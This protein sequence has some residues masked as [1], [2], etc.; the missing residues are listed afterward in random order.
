MKFYK[1]LAYKPLTY[2]LLAIFST[3]ILFA[4][5]SSAPEKATQNIPKVKKETPNKPVYKPFNPSYLVSAAKNRTKHKVKYDGRYIP[6]KYPMGDVP[7]NIGV[8]TDVVV[9]AYRRM[10][11]DLQ[12][13]VHED[14]KRAFHVY[15]SQKVWGKLAPDSNIDHRRVLNLEAFFKRHGKSLPLSRDPKNFRPGDLVTWRIGGIAPHIGI[16]IDKKAKD[17]KT[18]LIVHNDSR[19]P[20]E[21]DILFSPQFTMTGHYRYWPAKRV[22]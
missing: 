11:I 6:L 20:V 2:K 17:G 1:P 18:P 3:A 14:M 21:E 16:V 22:R 15:P 7:N 12:H 4:G 19:G 10:G 8:C 5:C 9:R 13:K